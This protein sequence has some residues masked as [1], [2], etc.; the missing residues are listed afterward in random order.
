[1]S[2]NYF[3]KFP[4]LYYQFSDENYKLAV[5][6]LR[7]VKFDNA[8]RDNNNGTIDYTIKDGDKP[9]NI[10]H[11]FYGSSNLHWIILLLN[12]IVSVYRDWPLDSITLEKVIDDKYGS[13][14]KNDINH[15]KIQGTDITVDLPSYLLFETGQP[16]IYEGGDLDG[17]FVLLYDGNIIGIN[18]TIV[19]FTHR[20]TEILAN[21]KKR[22]IKL[23]RPEYTQLA[24]AQLR[25][26]IND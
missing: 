3:D 20:Q 22:Y 9:E 12:D 1:M 25:T 4:L 11:R 17:E 15:G 7:R 19:L 5:D 10:A 2:V 6:I 24:L 13:S 14:K 26:K 21:E 8:L 16:V 18:E 23:L